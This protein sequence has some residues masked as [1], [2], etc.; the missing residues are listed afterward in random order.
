MKT[1]SGWIKTDYRVQSVLGFVMILLISSGLLCG[2][3]LL[4]GL[5]DWIIGI[6]YAAF[7]TLL[8]FMPLGLWQVISGIIHAFHGDKLQQIYLGVVAI[9][10]SIVYFFYQIND[11][12]RLY[13]D[14]FLILMG[15][16]ALI[17]AVWKYTVVRADYISLK[18]IDVPKTES[19]DLLD[20]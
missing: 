16:I 13:N 9:Y 4:L 18:I 2:L 17:I 15:V 6:Y 10:F 8:L 14:V 1:N 20:A 3:L 12:Q 5:E 11:Y 19:D 7:L